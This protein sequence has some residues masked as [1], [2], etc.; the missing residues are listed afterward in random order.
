MKKKNKFSNLYVPIILVGFFFIFVLFERIYTNNDLL[1]MNSNSFELSMLS[2]SEWE[3]YSKNNKSSY[4][5]KSLII[6]DHLSSYS[7][8]IKDNVR[9]VLDTISVKSYVKDIEN[10]DEDDNLNNY[11]TIIICI[12]NLDEL[13]YSAS[14]LENFVKNGGGVLFAVNILDSN[15]LKDYYV[16]EKAKS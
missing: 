6:Y 3:I 8:E 5:E 12:Q 14:K 10:I 16:K 11:S 9:Y 4:Q 1:N 13:N 15:N 2:D 7:V